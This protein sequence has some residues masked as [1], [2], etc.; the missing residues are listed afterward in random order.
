MSADF[1]HI[2]YLLC[3]SKSY[4]GY[5]YKLLITTYVPTSPSSKHKPLKST[6]PHHN[7]RSSINPQPYFSTQYLRTTPSPSSTIPPSNALTTD[8]PKIPSTHSQTKSAASH[9]ITHQP[10]PPPRRTN[11]TRS[12]HRDMSKVGYDNSEYR[13]RGGVEVF[14][15]WRGLVGECV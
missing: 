2:F 10:P 14:L 1:F 15:S 3:S 12:L 5:K 13:G 7:E 4:K 6:S 9:D 11:T 8:P